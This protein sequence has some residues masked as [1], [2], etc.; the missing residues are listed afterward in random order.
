MKDGSPD[1]GG[2]DVIP[3]K[4]RNLNIAFSQATNVKTFGS[5][6]LVGMT[7]FPFYSGEPER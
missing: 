1:F 4:A 5:S 3:S 2:K 6:L 7:H